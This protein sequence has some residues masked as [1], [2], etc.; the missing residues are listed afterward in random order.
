MNCAN[1][2]R[3]LSELAMDDVAPCDELELATHLR[4]CADCAKRIERERG[5]TML[6]REWSEPEFKDADRER[7]HAR[8]HT[9]IEEEARGSFGFGLTVRLAAAA[10]IAALALLLGL[11]GVSRV[12]GPT[13]GEAMAGPATRS[14]DTEPGVF[15]MVGPFSAK[16]RVEPRKPVEKPRRLESRPRRVS[17]RVAE[18]I[19]TQ[20]VPGLVLGPVDSDSMMRFEFQTEDPKIRIIWFVPRAEDGSSTT[21]EIGD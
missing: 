6:L 20:P 13:G 17:R 8:I 5:V 4:D 7:L 10:S 12:G 19:P 3:H 18:P 15:T 2:N 21:S 16:E 1:V 14:E 11:A 9:V